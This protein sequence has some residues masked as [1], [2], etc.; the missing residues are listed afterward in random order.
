LNV[1]VGSTNGWWTDGS[2][3]KPWVD[4][5]PTAARDFWNARDQWYPTWKENGQMR[6]KS[7]KVWQQGGYQGC[8]GTKKR[9]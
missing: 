8:K 1:A 6:V 5:S 7:I 4:S 9:R 3:G 2:Q